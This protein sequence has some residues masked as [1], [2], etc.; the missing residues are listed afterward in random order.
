MSRVALNAELSA[1]CHAT[2]DLE[3]VKAALM[4]VIPEEMRSELEGAF[5]ISMLEGHYGN[6]IFVLKVKMDKPEQAETLL[7]RLL[8]SLPPSDLM[9]L[10]R[11]LKLRLDSSGHLYLRL[12]KQRA[13]LG[14]IRVY[15]GDDVIRV[16]VKLSP[17]ARQIALSKSSL[18]D[19]L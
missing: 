19:L 10:E 6:P 16:R 13:Y 18:K 8:A 15:D 2:E 7:K 1:F 9:M 12:D 11:T 3:K 17:Q 4:N 14:E 5:S